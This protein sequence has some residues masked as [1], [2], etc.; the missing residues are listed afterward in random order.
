MFT[1]VSALLTR[2][3]ALDDGEAWEVFNSRYSPLLRRFFYSFGVAGDPARD[4]TQDTIQ[5]AIDGLRAGT[6]RRDKGRLRD[7]IG[8]IA[9]N[10]LR[11]SRRAGHGV[12][13]SV[14]AR[15]VFWTSHP[16]PGADDAV[17]EVDERFDQIWVRARLSALLRYALTFFTPRDLRCYFLVHVRERPIAEV[18]ERLGMSVSAVYQRRRAVAQWFL[19]VGPRFVSQWE[20]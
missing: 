19:A 8:G 3:P 16:D 12:R 1:T 10:V 4:L 13:G 14:Q 7:W 5:R 9:K 17:R 2:L 11:E 20:R 15:T 18:A 6:Y